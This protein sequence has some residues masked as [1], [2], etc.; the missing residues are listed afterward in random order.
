MMMIPVVSS[1]ETGLIAG[2]IILKEKSLDV[3]AASMAI[4]T[5]RAVME[6]IAAQVLNEPFSV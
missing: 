1:K 4:I 6:N 3:R 2:V 5:I